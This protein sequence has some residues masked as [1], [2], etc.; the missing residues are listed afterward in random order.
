MGMEVLEK[1]FGGAAKVKII[2][3][4]IFN[5]ESPFDTGSICE[6]ARVS[7]DV[8]RR[9]CSNLEKMKL[10]RSKSFFKNIRRKIRGKRVW[11]KKRLNGWILN[12]DFQYIEPLENFLSATNPF[13][14]SAAVSKI[15]RAGK[16]QL[17]LI[18]GIFI[19]N[20]GSRVDMLI[21]GDN[22]RKSS[23]ENVI[24][25]IESEMGRE[26][27]YAIFDTKDFNYRL[28]MF[29]KLTRDILDYPHQKII[30]KLNI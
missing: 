13:K 26:I 4:F 7:K 15:S 30:N 2:K 6:R 11:V 9:E 24:K 17:L 5:R 12:P 21:V 20:P 22:L 29:D 27:K 25:I 23:L 28:N 8:A 14:N 18:S 10:I 3:L 16:I 1:L 19:K